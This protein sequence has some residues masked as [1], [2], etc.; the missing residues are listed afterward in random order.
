MVV[1]SLHLEWLAF[2]YRIHSKAEE[3]N[4]KLSF[5]IISVYTD[6]NLIIVKVLSSSKVAPGV[7]KGIF[8]TRDIKKYICM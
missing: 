7:F 4:F 1:S 6:D 2:K 5:M 8:D 3:Y